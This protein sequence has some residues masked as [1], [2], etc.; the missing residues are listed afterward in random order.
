M[1]NL[2]NAVNLFG[3]TLDWNT[4]DTV[5]WLIVIQSILAVMALSIIIYV[6]LRRRS[7]EQ[8]GDAVTTVAQPTTQD[9]VAIER[10]PIG[11][12]LDVGIVQRIFTAGDEFTCEGMVVNADYN[13][14]PTKESILEYTLI[15][16]DTYTRLEKKGKAHKLFFLFR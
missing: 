10:V 13:V 16:S 8:T 15:D 1:K 6:V 14:A 11:I 7:R 4:Y 12:S 5:V 2:L 3:H 9:T